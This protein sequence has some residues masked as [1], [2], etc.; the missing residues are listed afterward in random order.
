MNSYFRYKAEFDKV[1][2]EL[3][4]A[5]GVKCFIPGLDPLK[6]G[7]LRHL[8]RFGYVVETAGESG[9]VFRITDAGLAV[10]YWDVSGLVVCLLSST[11]RIAR[12]E[13]GAATATV[14]TKV[15]CCSR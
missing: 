14:S 4:A 9:V 15:D 2:L 11:T 5:G 7:H 12:S 3:V 13:A 1:L 10:L 8:I 6:V